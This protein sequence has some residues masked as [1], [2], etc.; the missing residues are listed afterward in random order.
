MSIETSRLILEK[1][2]AEELPFLAELFADPMVMRYIGNGL[3][4]TTEEAA[5]SI[6]TNQKHWD[7]FGFG[8]W[9]IFEK[10]SKEFIGRGGLIHLGFQHEHP[11]IELG[12]TLHQ[13]F[14]GKGYAT[15]IAQSL[16]KWAKENLKEDHLLGV[17]Y[18]QNLASQK[19]LKKIGMQFDREEVY[20]RTDFKSLFF[21]LDLV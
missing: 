21:R 10:G 13:K 19:V 17:C 16:V 2:R 6:E 4:R 20:P 14:W 15:E 18:K 11:E 9:S 12:Y 8:F 1:P 7:A 5:K 3:P